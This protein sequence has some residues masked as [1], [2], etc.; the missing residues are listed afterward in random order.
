MLRSLLIA[1]TLATSACAGPVTSSRSAKLPPQLAA[2]EVRQGD[3][4]AMPEALLDAARQAHLV[5]VGEQH[6]DHAHHKFQSALFDALTDSSKSEEWPFALGMEMFQ[7]QYQHVLDDYL[8]RR[9]DD[10]ELVQ[11]S[12]WKER[13]GFDYLMYMPMLQSARQK[14]VQLIALNAPRELTRLVA[15]RGL[16]GLPSALKNQMPEL[17]LDDQEHRRFFWTIMGFD[18]A[19]AHDSP[20]QDNPHQDNP[21]E[22][23]HRK[24]PH[25]D[26]A[27]DS[28]HGR[29]SAENFYAAQV[30]W[31]E[32]MAESAAAWLSEPD[33][34]I[35]IVAGNGHCHDSAIVRRVARRRP[36]IKTLSV[37]LEPRDGGL[38]PHATSDF[39]VR[40][41]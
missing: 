19:G 20:H 11:Q 24:N 39:V 10:A 22:S 37:L 30:V 26:A 15:R 16:D 38:P 2:A 8:E 21:H 25:R 23:P 9:V 3:Q 6:D 1:L 14:R 33:R 34:H 35:M 12:E 36:G 28:A 27:H 13:W 32:T 40:V 4:S 31:D 7:R 17:L 29:A 41:H 18:R 5:C